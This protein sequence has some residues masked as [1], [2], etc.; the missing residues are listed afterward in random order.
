M[1]NTHFISIV[2]LIISIL[3]YENIAAA[4]SFVLESDRPDRQWLNAFD[5]AKKIKVD[6]SI[7]QALL[8]CPEQ[9]YCELLVDQLLLTKTIEINRSKIKITGLTGNRIR[10]AQNRNTN[11][12]FFRITKGVNQVI[13]SELNLDG[14]SIEKYPDVYGIGSYASNISQIM[15]TN[16]RIANFYGHENA[17]AIAF[18]GNGATDDESI[19][20]I[21]IE[22]N[23]VSNM[24][25]GSSES[26]VINGN[27][28]HWEIIGNRI[29]RVNNI[30]IDAI[31]GEGIAPT[32]NLPD[33]RSGP[34]NMDA[35]RFGFIENNIVTDMST[36]NNPAYGSKESWAGAIYIDGA[37]SIKVSGNTVSNTPWG[38]VIGAENCVTSSHIQMYDNTSQNNRYGDVLIGGYAEGGY[39]EDFS[40]NC[41]PHTSEDKSEGHGYVSNLDV[42][43]NRLESDLNSS[44]LFLG[45]T[46]LQHRIKKSTIEPPHV[47]FND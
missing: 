3:F 23:E 39:L 6:E 35:A 18:Y 43:N 24:R 28:R 47:R 5:G 4:S 13:F 29:K 17:H 40:I 44:N 46:V 14:E 37:H 25:T 7:E 8:K 27:V 36:K 45:N 32:Q 26:I 21:I 11:G 10:M 15:V 34:G 20:N 33:G 9:Q 2:W 16:N 12:F 38:L 22:N 19:N 41:N 42:R 1:R 30:A 31:G